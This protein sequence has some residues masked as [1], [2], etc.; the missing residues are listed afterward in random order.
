MSL[1]S[2]PSATPGA[3]SPPPVAKMLMT[4]PLRAGFEAEFKLPSSFKNRALA[5]AGAGRQPALLGQAEGDQVRVPKQQDHF[6][7]SAHGF[8]TCDLVHIIFCV[9]Y[10]PGQ[11]R[12]R[13]ADSRA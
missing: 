2:W 3:A 9:P 13:R 1:R 8:V 12:L 4:E 5:L 11:R 7:Q 10:Y 6:R